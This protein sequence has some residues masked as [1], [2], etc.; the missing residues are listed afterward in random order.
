M[1]N[2]ISK[3]LSV[4]DFLGTASDYY[5]LTK[6][7]IT[8][9][10]VASMLIGFLMGSAGSVN[11]IT[12]IHAIF[13]T[14]LIAA[15]TAA[16]N[17]FME[18][19]LDGIMR[20]TSQRPLPA[21]RIEPQ[22]SLIFSM[23]L[24]IAGLAYLLLLVNLVA[25]LVSLSTTIIYLYAY[26]PL[27]RI[28][29][30]NVFVGA[31]PG[32]LPVVGGWAAST[33]TIFEHGMW[34]LF[35]IIYCWQIPHVMAIAWVCKDDYEHAGFKMLPKNDPYGWKASLWILIPLI[36]L[37]PTVYKLYVMDLVNWLYLSGS[38]ITTAAYLY[39]GIRFTISRDRSTAKALMFSSFVY[40]PLIWIFI[41][42]DWM[43]L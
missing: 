28:S 16:H 18:R 10:V 4:K 22:K 39:Y 15:G 29:A 30:L 32:A 26:T 41:F 11:F 37:I 35:G 17:M 3:K 14:Y 31:I 23:S 24:I 13:G 1:N 34:I 25:G 42:A 12:M 20:R 5:Q 9:T 7:G 27:K 40:L 21:Y 8:F 19:D 38:L 36:I 43:I 2:S 6:P 33:G